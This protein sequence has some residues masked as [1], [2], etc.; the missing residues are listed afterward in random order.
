MIRREEMYFYPDQLSE[1]FKEQL[2]KFLSI[3]ICIEG[4]MGNAKGIPP[5][6]TM[7][8]HEFPE[9]RHRAFI[10]NKMADERDHAFGLF[11][12]AKG[13]GKDPHALLS[14]VRDDPSKTRALDAMKEL[15]RIETH[16]EF[17]VL[18]LL[19]EAA[20]GIAS[21]GM[22]GGNYLPWV[23]WNARNFLDEGLTHSLLSMRQVREAVDNGEGELAQEFY[24][25]HY[26]FWLD[27]FGA[28]NSANED[29]YLRYG[30]KTLTNTECRVI[31]L[32][33]MRDR[34]AK[35]GLRFP[36]DPY[37][38]KRG[39]YDECEEG[40][41]GNWGAFADQVITEAQVY[42]VGVRARGT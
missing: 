26:P 13:I 29:A 34:T 40:L 16:L 11:Q 31:W 37:Q 4:G 30:I 27:A 20:G 28:A 17:E 33:Q 19:G 24:D 32:R 2:W 41:E 22:V 38:G 15:D 3:Q 35:A 1:E 39:R 18:C 25:H 14:A 23:M 6:N 10:N 36:Q 5:R 42:G 9:T 7:L 12:V 21:L 8:A